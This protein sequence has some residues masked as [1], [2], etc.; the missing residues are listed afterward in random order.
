MDRDTYCKASGGCGAAESFRQQASFLSQSN[1]NCTSRRSRVDR[2]TASVHSMYFTA[3]TKS[4]CVTTSWPRTALTN[5]LHPPGA[6]F[7]G[8]DYKRA[9]RTALLTEL[10]VGLATVRRDEGQ[11]AFV[12]QNPGFGL[13]RSVTDHRR[14]HQTIRSR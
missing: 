3:V 7:C 4:V 8:I 6:A 1:G 5:F 2:V 13:A 9:H 10:Q 12:A 14:E 11:R